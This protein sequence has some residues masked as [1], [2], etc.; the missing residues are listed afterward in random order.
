M[1]RAFKV[2]TFQASILAAGGLMMGVIADM[3]KAA[4]APRRVGSDRQFHLQG[5]R[6][7]R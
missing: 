2:L 6:S 7:L 4:P 1:T 3:A 5:T